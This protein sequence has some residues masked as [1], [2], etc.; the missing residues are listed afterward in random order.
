MAAAAIAGS[1]S[2]RGRS[3]AAAR[4]AATAPRSAT[5]RRSRVVGAA[6]ATLAAAWCLRHPASGARALEAALVLCADHELNV[7][8]FAARCAAS[9]EA[10]PWDAVGAGLAA[11]RGR[12]H[13]GASLRAEALLR[14][15][16]AG[17][18]AAAVGER[19]RRGEPLPGFGHPLYPGGDPRGA[20][21]VA[22]AGRLAPRS[23]AVGAARRLAGAA[24]DLLGERPNLDLGLA[25]LCAAL[26][27]PAGSSIALF[28]LGRTVGWVAHA[29]EEYARERL[30]RPRARYVGPAP[31]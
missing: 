16:E 10:T 12:R 15:A 14:E 25:V 11:L 13:G 8:T 24:A 1:A 6:A 18:P 26:R 9:A 22:L 17:D 7:S 21:L 2:P 3:A 28:A 29:R 23:R 4:P 31:G 30:I 20:E 27:L 19:L 5:R